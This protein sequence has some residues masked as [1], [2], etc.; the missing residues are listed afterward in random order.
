MERFRDRTQRAW[1]KNVPIWKLCGVIPLHQGNKEMVC[2]KDNQTQLLQAARKLSG[3][4]S[5]EQGS[6]NSFFVDSDQLI[7]EQ[8]RKSSASAIT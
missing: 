2:M 8:K 1:T 6:K 5:Q 4:V 3:L 7:A